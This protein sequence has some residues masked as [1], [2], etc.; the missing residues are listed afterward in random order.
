MIHNGFRFLLRGCDLNCFY[1]LVVPA[2]EEIDL[3]VG[4][5]N[6]GNWINFD[7]K[8]IYFACNFTFWY[9]IDNICTGN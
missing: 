2:G 6:D 8:F 4:V 7:A 3:L 5:K 1:D 9:V